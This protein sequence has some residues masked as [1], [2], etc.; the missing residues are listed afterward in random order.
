[1]D[2]S[3]AQLEFICYIGLFISALLAGICIVAIICISVEA[4]KA[5]RDEINEKKKNECDQKVQRTSKGARKGS[6]SYNKHPK[7]KGFQTQKNRKQVRQHTKQS[8]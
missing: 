6:K 8:H 2:Y 1:M 7:G 4:V 5:R 3:L